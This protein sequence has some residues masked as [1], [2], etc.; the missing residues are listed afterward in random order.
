MIHKVPSIFN[1]EA[2]EILSGEV[3]RSDINEL[4]SLENTL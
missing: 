4:I 2:C 1:V 3:L